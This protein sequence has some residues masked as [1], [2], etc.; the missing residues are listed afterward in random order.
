ME[1][2]VKFLKDAHARSF[3][4]AWITYDLGCELIRWAGDDE[5]Q[6]NEGIH[7]IQSAS[8]IFK[9]EVAEAIPDE[10]YL[11]SVLDDTR[12]KDLIKLGVKKD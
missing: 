5:I 3:Q 9:K 7:M 1:K 8:G 12:I 11:Q 4:A 2:S 10:P 6:N